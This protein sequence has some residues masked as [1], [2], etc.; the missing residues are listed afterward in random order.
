M[1]RTVKRLVEEVGV[2]VFDAVIV[3]D[4]N[5]VGVRVVDSGGAGD[6][7]FGR[8]R[9][10]APTIC[11]WGYDGDEVTEEVAPLR[12]RGF[13][14]RRL[15]VHWGNRRSL[16]IAICQ[17]SIISGVSATVGAPIM[18]VELGTFHGLVVAG[19][20]TVVVAVL[21]VSVQH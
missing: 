11:G 4:W 17:F 21:I 12:R 19:L 9:G 13:G 20:P 14:L 1:P 5:A 15:A 6:H 2:G 7:G 16:S 3:G 8:V 18:G 10:L